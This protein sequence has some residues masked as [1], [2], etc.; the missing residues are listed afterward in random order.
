MR[1][2]STGNAVFKLCYHLVIITKY[3]KKILTKEM[4]ADI[5]EICKGILEK[6]SCKILE[7]NGEEDHIHI[8]FETL[9]TAT[10]TKLVNSIK[11]VSSRII[12]K[13]YNLQ[14]LKTGKSILWSPSYFIATCGEIKIEILKKYIENQGK[15]FSPPKQSLEGA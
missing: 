2:L 10:L 3:R 14:S 12:R 6:N 15:R 8:L 5:N 9:P 11:T 4:I 1:Y 7:I 13:K